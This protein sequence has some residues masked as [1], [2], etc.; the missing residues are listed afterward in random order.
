MMKN[1]KILRSLLAGFSLIFSS[2]AGAVQLDL[3]PVAGS[4]FSVDDI[5]QVEVF[6]SGLTSS[7]APSLGAY[8]INVGYDSGL[9]DYLGVNYSTALGD[10]GLFEVLTLTDVSLAGTV[11]TTAI[12]LLESDAATCIFCLGPYLDDIQ[13]DSFSLFTLEFKA[14]AVG[15]GVFDISPLVISDGFGNALSTSLGGPLSINISE[16][17]GVP[18]PTPLILIGSGLLLLL[19]IRKRQPQ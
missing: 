16:P 7:G 9:V 11:N 18:T 4:S 10:E 19:K 5:F 12:S 17:H 13:A 6:A 3:N 2:W 14:V 8:D 15:S 1:T